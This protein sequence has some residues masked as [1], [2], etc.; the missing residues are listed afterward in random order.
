[1]GIYSNA[2][3]A[4]TQPGQLDRRVTLYSAIAEDDAIGQMVRTWVEEDVVWAAWAPQTGREVQAAA[5]LQVQ[6]LGV[7]RIRYRSDIT[8]NWRV[9]L[10]DRLFEIIAPPTEIGR[11]AFLDLAVRGLNQPAEDTMA[12][13]IAS[14]VGYNASSNA[15]GTTTIT[16][17]A[18]RLTHKE[19]TTIS[20]SG[21]TTRLMV[22]AITPTPPSGASIIHR[23]TVPATAEITIEWRNAT[24]GGTLITSAITDGSGDD[25]VAEFVF[26]GA[27]WQFTRFHAPANA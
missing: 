24:A 3:S 16:P 7:L 15:A 27:A 22:L 20:G 13:F 21:S 10:D 14:L 23:L 9:T 5:Q 12:S 11:R 25:M 8:S 1:M 17:T 26:D 2:L 19:T 4:R 6:S 18:R